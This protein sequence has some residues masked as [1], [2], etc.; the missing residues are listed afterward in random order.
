M[1]LFGNRRDGSGAHGHANTTSHYHGPGQQC[2]H[3]HGPSSSAAG[4]HEQQ[5]YHRQHQAAGGALGQQGQTRVAQPGMEMMPSGIGGGGGGGGRGG[6]GGLGGMGDLGASLQGAP[7]DVLA[8]AERLSLISPMMG[9]DLRGVVSTVPGMESTDTGAL[10]VSLFFYY[11]VLRVFFIFRL[12]LPSLSV[13]VYSTCLLL[14][15]G[16]SD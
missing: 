5:H 12:F 3:N 9:G 14:V 10:S 1:S 2:S 6:V 15:P 11:G 8:A 7:A 4:S 16:I 13:F